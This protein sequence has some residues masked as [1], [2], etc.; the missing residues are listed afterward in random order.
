MN[1][2]N[3]CKRGKYHLRGV[4]RGRIIVPGKQCFNVDR[5]QIVYT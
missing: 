4:C 1:I 5:L 3:L 2:D